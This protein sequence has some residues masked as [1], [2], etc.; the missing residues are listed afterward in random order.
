M[1][2]Y[3]PAQPGVIAV[4]ANIGGKEVKGYIDAAKLWLEPPLDLASSDRYMV[5]TETTSVHVVPDP[6]SPPVLT[7]LQGEVVDAVG[8][9]NYQGRGWVKARF[10]VPDRPRYGFIPASE[11][12]TPFRRF[13]QSV[14]RGPGRGTQTDARLGF[15]V[16]RSGP[17]EAVAGRFLYRTLTALE[18][19]VCR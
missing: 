1:G 7:L 10:N 16:F 19:G 4:R 6:A 17:E 14:G 2:K 3:D 18:T 11:D 15:E 13:R 12:E 8:V 5:V 9:L